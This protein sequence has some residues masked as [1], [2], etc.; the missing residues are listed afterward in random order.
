MYTITVQSSPLS[1][2]AALPSHPRLQTSY[3]PSAHSVSSPSAPSPSSLAPGCRSMPPASFPTPESLRALQWN[4]GGLRARSTELLHFL[5]SNPVDLVCIQESNLNSSSSF[6]I[7]GFSVLRSDH[8][9]SRSG[10]LSPD[11]KHASGSVII[12][13]RQGLSFS[14]LSSSYLSSL[15]PYSDYVGVDISLNN[16]S[17]LSFL[18]VYMFPLFAPLRSM[19]EPIPFLPPFFPPPEISSFWG[20]SIS[21]TPSGT[22]E[23]LPIPARR[24]Y[25]TGLSPLTCSPSMTLTHLLFSI[26]SSTEISFAP[27]FLALERCF[28]TWVLTTYQFFYLSL[29]LRFIATTSVLL[30]STFR[31]LAGMTLFLT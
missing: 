25:S 17:S 23:V 30:P 24:K 5:S 29:S 27:S 12:F 7:P 20:T 31:K 6:R 2:N 28:R 26:A 14:E 13:V 21:I 3:P 8:N 11:A 9:H 4:A 10:I 15:D 18:N 19:P 1:A 22:Q 16:S